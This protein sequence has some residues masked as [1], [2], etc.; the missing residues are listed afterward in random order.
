MSDC[1]VA[2]GHLFFFY[3]YDVGFDI[4]LSDARTLSEAAES[5]GLTG[6]R[7]G[8]PHLQYQ[9]KPMA[10]PSGVVEVMHEGAVFRMEAAVKI[11]DFGALS[12]TLCLPVRDLPWEEYAA[13]ALK[14]AGGSAME[15][16]ARE[17]ASGLFAKILPA[18]KRAG[19][20][21]LVEEYNLWH[22]GSFAP[23]L[24]ASQAMERL[25]QDIARLLTLERGTFSEAALAEI[26]RNPIRYFENDFCLPDWNAAFLCD[27]KYQDT[28]E[29]LEFLNVQMLELRFFDRILH[30]ALDDMAEE[31]RKK[32]GI[33]SVLHDPFES[34]LRKLS[35]IKM[36]VSLLRERINNAL[37]L[38]GDVYLARIYEEARR[39]AGA[40]KWEGTIRDQLKALEDIYTI[41]NNRAAA[42]RAE[43]LE[44][45]IILLIALEIVMGL[46]RH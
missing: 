37:K 39:K 28:V 43:T 4:S 27:P 14:L 45:I 9:P 1:R 7:P 29:V 30:A 34:P 22:V 10:V 5:T 40:E 23:E 42:S 17:I 36:D 15:E 41:L 16:A 3:A 46:L 12:V 11:F 19:F 44:M 31:L 18:V 6:L 2:W 20:A 24:S 26:L 32:R 35:E 33:L 25:Q 8:P 38:A 13:T 21:D